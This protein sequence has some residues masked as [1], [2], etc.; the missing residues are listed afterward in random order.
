[1]LKNFWNW[2]LRRPKKLAYCGHVLDCGF[3]EKGHF[4]ML[5]KI[6]NG[7]LYDLMANIKKTETAFGIQLKGCNLQESDNAN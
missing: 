5:V 2:L 1:M 3:N 4:V 6:D 7:N